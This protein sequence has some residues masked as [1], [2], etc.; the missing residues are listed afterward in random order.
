MTPGLVGRAIAVFVVAS[1]AGVSR[2]AAAGTEPGPV[3]RIP[4]LPDVPLPPGAQV[5]GPRSG[6]GTP[7]PRPDIFRDFAPRSAME[8]RDARGGPSSSGK[9]PEGRS[10]A[11]SL[12]PE[13]KRA[14]IRKALTPPPPAVEARRKTLDGLYAQL[15]A[16]KDEDDSR[17]LAATIGA[18]WM[19]SG[20][21]TASLLISRAETAVAAHNFTLAAQVLD[22]LVQLQP[23]WA[24]AWNKRA[25][26]RYL[27]GN[28]DGAMADIDRVLK[29]EPNHFAALN[30]MAMI[31]QQTG[32]NKRALQVYRRELAIYPH[33]PA[34]ERLV[35][36]LT[37]EVE[38][39][40]I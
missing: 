24:E 10:P 20:S 12:T 29:L 39:Q 11:A 14:Q 4:G 7:P 35:E 21:D 9:A 17:R 27:A 34:V 3:L 26:V 15:A 33:Q 36:Q 37:V 23:T 13:Q 40:G 2:L 5:F 22:R 1:C 19:R 8:P 18:V 25:T 6:D 31:L 38:G 28:L 32:F 30:G 16:A